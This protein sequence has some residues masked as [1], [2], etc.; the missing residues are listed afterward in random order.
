[1]RTVLFALLL[2]AAATGC[3]K[4]SKAVPAA[5]AATEAA[6]GNGAPPAESDDGKDKSSAK[7]DPCDG[8]ET[9][10]K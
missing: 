9:K 8:G 5:P 6:P 4:K 2:A 7:G 10:G 3:A 1:M